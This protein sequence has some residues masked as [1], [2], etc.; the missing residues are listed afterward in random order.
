MKL[1]GIDIELLGHASFKIKSKKKVIYIDPFKLNNAQSTDKADLILITHDHFD[2]CSIEDLKLIIKTETI[3]VSA[4][5]CKEKL[6]NSFL[7]S[8]NLIL[9]SPFE[10]IKVLDFEIETIPAYN[11]NKNFHPKASNWVGYII[12]AGKKI[13]HSGD[14][15]FIDEMKK[16]HADIV[17]LPVSGT[18]VMTAEEAVEAAYLIK[19]KIA[20]PMH[21]GSLV[22][23]N[24]DA[25]RFKELLEQRGIKVVI[26]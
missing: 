13:Y 17:L 7:N 14:T 1:L 10:K 16:V 21:Y 8:K 6:D 3:I 11:K 9:V 2:H 22:G 25:Q 4:K 23:T 18:Y 20:I 26:L 15:D 24:E 12:T 19:P 5:D